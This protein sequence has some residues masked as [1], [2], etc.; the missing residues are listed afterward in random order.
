V[1]YGKTIR[2][3]LQAGGLKPDFEYTAQPDAFLDWIHRNADGSD[4]YFIFNRRDRT[5]TANC[6]FRVTGKQPELWDP[7]TGEVRDAAVFA[8]ADGRTTLPM[9]FAPYESVFVVFRQATTKTATQR[10]KNAPS[11]QPI[12]ELTSSWSVAFDP[13]WLY[14]K[15][16]GEEGEKGSTVAFDKLV[17]WT[18][19]PEDG[20]K[21]YS[22]KAVYRKT[23]DAPG[24]KTPLAGK[25][26][27]DLGRVHELAEVRLNGKMLGVV[28]TAPWRI[29]VTGSIK[30]AG[31]ELEIGVVNLWPNRL[32]G[33][34]PL[35]P[36]QRRTRTNHGAYYQGKH[37]LL[38]SGLLGPVTL[39]AA[40]QAESKQ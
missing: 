22:G 21:F 8:Q 31:N 15:L 28:W 19:R 34:G 12:Q 26:Y 24:A 30:P 29:E 13:D 2:D 40:E 25:L 23:F 6:T 39:Q 35:P 11:L 18:Q 16:D 1:V 7:V 3:V 14:P 38:P 36:E 32:I 9:E 4:I 27:L 20:I 17:D 33:D 5:E 10:R 37:S